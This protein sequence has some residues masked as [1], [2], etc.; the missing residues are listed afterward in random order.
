MNQRERM[1]DLTYA[2]F[3]SMEAY[4]IDI[5]LIQN[6][7]QGLCS[8]MRIDNISTRFLSICGLYIRYGILMVVSITRL[9]TPS[10]PKDC[11]SN[12][13]NDPQPIQNPWRER[14]V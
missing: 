14:G 11:E 2:D 8:G 3:C 10:L 13:G 9:Q 6:I 7:F 5:F 12:E 1:S 4:I